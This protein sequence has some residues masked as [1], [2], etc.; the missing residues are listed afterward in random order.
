MPLT[1]NKLFLINISNDKLIATLSLHVNDVP[2][3]VTCE[4]LLRQVRGMKIVV[5]EEGEKAVGDFVSDLANKGVPNPVVI[6]QGRKP[7]ADTP[8]QIEVLYNK[9]SDSEQQ[10]DESGEPSRQSHYNRSSIIMATEGQELLRLIPPGQGEN[11]TDVFGKEIPRK[12]A[13]DAKI[14]LGPNVRQEGDTIYATCSGRVE[15]TD[16]KIAINPKLV[17]PGNVDF[18]VGNI[19]S[20]GD[21]EIGKNVLDLFKVC[22]GNDIDIQGVAE[23]AEIHA[24]RD[25]AIRGG[26]AGK[27]KGV[28]TAGRDFRSKYVTNAKVKAGGDVE[29][30]KEIVQCDLSCGGRLIVENGDLIGGHTFAIGG[31]VIGNLGSESNVKTVLE[32]GIHH[33]LRRQYETLVPEIE[34]RRVKANKVTEIVTPLLQNQKHLTAEQKEK[35]T[36]LLYQAS[37][38]EDT[39]EQMLEQLRHLAPSHDETTYPEVVINGVVYPGCVIRFPRVEMRIAAALSGPIRIVPRRIEGILSIVA[40][41]VASGSTHDLNGTPSEKGFWLHLDKLIRTDA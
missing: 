38:L 33:D 5:D 37:E 3:N 32:V 21:V 15:H 22:G 41:D 20:P 23:A 36:E 30:G 31:A 9:T 8:G 29:V 26:V 25:L 18:S 16:G 10:A 14:H 34:K 19:D 4:E 28:F 39:A 6:S 7:I 12:L 17:I 35:A 2:N 24:Q 40:I 11:G 13:T 1:A 27:D